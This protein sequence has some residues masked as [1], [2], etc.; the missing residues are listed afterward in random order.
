MLI[1]AFSLCSITPLHPSLPLFL[2]QSKVGQEDIGEALQKMDKN[3]DG[4]MNIKE[5]NQSVA[6]LA[7]GYVENGECKGKLHH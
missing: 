4:Q 5:F 2:S 3:H 1:I 7:Q 6:I